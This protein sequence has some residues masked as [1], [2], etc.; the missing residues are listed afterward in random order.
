[1]GKTY[2][3]VNP[4]VVAWNELLD[5]IDT[6]GRPLRRLAWADW[7]NELRSAAEQSTDN[8][9]YPLLPVLT[10]EPSAEAGEA[11]EDDARAPRIDCARTQAALAGG[12]IEC[13]RLDA[14]LLGLYLDRLLPVE[15]STEEL[16][17]S[18]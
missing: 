3:L 9:L 2:H 6:L 5:W 18:R 14:Q 10:A 11:A 7:Q 4:R 15:L 1:V 13:P 12:G 17:V 8:V 16:A